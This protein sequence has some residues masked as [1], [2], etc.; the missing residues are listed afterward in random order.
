MNKEQQ[1]RVAAIHDLSGF[2]KCSLTVALPILSAAGIET[3]ALPTAILSTHTG[4][5]LGYTYRDLTEDMRPFMKHWK[6][7]DIRF[8]AVYSGFL[9][10]FEQLDIVKEF[11][12]PKFAKGMRSLGE[13]A[14]IIVPNLTEAALL[15][16]EPYQAGP[17]TKAYIDGILHKLSQLGPKQVVLTGVYFDEK[18]LGAATFDMERNAT[19]YV[20]TEKIPGY[21]HGT[22]D[23]FASALLSGL[24]NN[25]NL[26]RSAEI[27]V[28]FTAESILRT[29]KA[30][31]DY[32]FGVNFEQ[33]IPDLLKELKLI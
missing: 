10:S 11:F 17:Y 20:L 6:E 19:E 14:D 15:L 5:I 23:V 7:L 16:G 3:S 30:Q 26:E 25:F 18:E 13:R 12:S 33:S 22:G 4:G 1:K 28:R 8:D 24:L 32:R 2:G 31:T 9:G 21:Y 29:F 27:A